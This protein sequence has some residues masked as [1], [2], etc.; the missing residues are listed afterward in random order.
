VHDASR[1]ALNHVD[2]N[3]MTLRVSGSGPSLN[4]GSGDL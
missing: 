2:V 4:F 1:N 3:P